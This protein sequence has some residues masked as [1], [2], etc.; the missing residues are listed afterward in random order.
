MLSVLSKEY[1]LSI[2]Q[3]KIIITACL[4]VFVTD[5]LAQCPDTFHA[6]S[7]AMNIDMSCQKIHGD[8]TKDETDIEVE[9]YADTT[10][11]QLVKA[12]YRE[13][14]VGRKTVQVFHFKTDSLFRVRVLIMTGDHVL[15]TSNY[16]FCRN[17]IYPFA[18]MDGHVKPFRDSEKKSQ[19]L[20]D[21]A[22]SLLST[23]R[24]KFLIN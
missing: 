20:I 14:F 7:I 4:F 12:V 21:R 16:Y 23:A 2:L 8:T 13:V 24:N 11:G 5:G 18:I 22:G 6:D 17:K 9:W 1:Q 19:E 15:S 3:M 10:T